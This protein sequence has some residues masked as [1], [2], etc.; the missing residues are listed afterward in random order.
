MEGR[1]ANRL[2]SDVI[3]NDIKAI[4]ELTAL[5]RRQTSWIVPGRKAIYKELENNNNNNN[6]NNNSDNRCIETE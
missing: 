1:T 5:L 3:I 4:L 2:H 6:N